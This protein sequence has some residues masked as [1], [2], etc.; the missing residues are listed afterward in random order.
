MKKVVIM[1]FLLLFLTGCVQ[2]E[3]KKAFD[4]QYFDYFDCGQQEVYVDAGAYD[5]YTVMDFLSWT[6]GNYKKCLYLN[7]CRICIK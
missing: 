6:K 7:L 5:G 3:Q 2:S 1:V 4:V